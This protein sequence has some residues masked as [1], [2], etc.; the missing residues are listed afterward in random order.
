LT[1]IFIRF[2]PVF[3]ALGLAGLAGA[4]Q[5]AQLFIPVRLELVGD[6]AVART[7]THEALAGQIGLEAGAPGLLAP[8]SVAVL[9]PVVDDLHHLERAAVQGMEGMGDDAGLHLIGPITR[10]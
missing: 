10:S 8:Q 3:C 6:Q 9:A 1:A 4:L 2:H 7:D 5:L